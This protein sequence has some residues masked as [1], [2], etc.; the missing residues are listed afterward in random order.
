MQEFA[1]QELKDPEA[2]GERPVDAGK[3]M[4]IKVAIETII[5]LPVVLIRHTLV[6]CFA[7]FGTI[8]LMS[9]DRYHRV[10]LVFGHMFELMT[11]I[12]PFM[13]I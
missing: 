1:N 3:E 5:Y 13:M 7:Y 10:F 2:I 4:G 12:V 6:Y 11:H 9:Q 8:R